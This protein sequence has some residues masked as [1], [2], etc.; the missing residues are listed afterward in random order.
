MT[1]RRLAALLTLPLAATLAAC[2][3]STS[4]KGSGSPVASST[5]STAAGLGKVMQAAAKTV[6][7][8]HFD[9]DVNAAG[10]SL[11]GSGDEKLSNG[12]LVA[13]DV[14]E[15]LPQGAGQIRVIIVGDK[16]YAKLPQALVK[17]SKPYILVTQNSSNPVIKQLA[18]TL[19]TALATA[20][21]GSVNSFVQAASSVQV[22]GSQTVNGEHTT[23]Y[24]V[25]VDPAKLPGPL[26]SQLA[27]SGLTSLPLELY[28]DDQGRPVM[29]TEDVAVAG[30]HVSTKV[31]VTDYNKPVTISAPPAS[32]VGTS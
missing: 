21:V 13:V 24:H 17:T 23:H 5:P 25:V 20:S 22:K 31:T 11:T 8:A 4:G 15:S 9:L 12:K 29:F 18:T 7:S 28:I 19:N 32:E 30:Q 26:K 6:T 2:S 14:T 27:T 1:G 16:T 10:Q 3:S